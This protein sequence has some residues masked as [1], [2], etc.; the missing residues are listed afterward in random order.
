MSDSFVFSIIVNP[1]ND[2]PYFNTVV[3][4]D[5][6]ILDEDTIYIYENLDVD[7]DDDWEL[8][9]NWWRRKNFVNWV[10]FQYQGGNRPHETLLMKYGDVKVDEYKLPNG[11]VTSRGIINVPSDTK[12]GKIS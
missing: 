10:W 1:V 3:D 11:K 8:M 5:S 4:A 9:E 2:A 6:D 7:R 12:V